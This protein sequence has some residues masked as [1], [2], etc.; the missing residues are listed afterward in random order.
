MGTY[1]AGNVSV[2]A[3]LFNPTGQLTKVIQT[4]KGYSLRKSLIVSP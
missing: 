2:R 3:M 4:S 1:D